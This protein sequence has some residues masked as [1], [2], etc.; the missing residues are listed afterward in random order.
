MISAD[1]F[2]GKIAKIIAQSSDDDR[3]AF[4]TRVAAQIAKQLF[5]PRTVKFRLIAVAIGL[6]LMPQHTRDDRSARRK[7]GTVYRV[8]IK[9]RPFFPLANRRSAVGTRYNADLDAVSVGIKAGKALGKIGSRKG[10]IGIY[11]AKHRLKS[12]VSENI[13]PVIIE[14]GRVSKKAAPRHIGLTDQQKRMHHKRTFFRLSQRMQEI[15]SAFP[16]KFYRAAR[17]P[18]RSLQRTASNNS[19]GRNGTARFR[20]N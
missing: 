20:R 5:Q 16:S 8:V 6:A 17:Y 7:A 11:G 19:G 3:N 12:S 18:F 14:C 1:F 15:I 2:V 4:K 13:Q 9:K 10:A